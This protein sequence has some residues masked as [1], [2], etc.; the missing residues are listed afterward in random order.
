MWQGTTGDP[1]ENVHSAKG[2]EQQLEQAIPG[3][4]QRL[5]RVHA[6]TDNMQS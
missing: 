2:K 4:D 5:L 6:R 3:G 1:R